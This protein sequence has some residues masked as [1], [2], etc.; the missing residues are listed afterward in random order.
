M[1]GKIALRTLH[2]DDERMRAI[3]LR[4]VKEMAERESHYRVAIRGLML[5]LLSLLLR[6]GTQERIGIGEG[7]QIARYYRAIEPALRKIRDCYAERF[8]VEE[9]SELCMV[10]KYHFCRVFKRV[11]GMSAMQYLN[12]YRLKIAETTLENTDRSVADVARACGFEDESYFCRCYKKHFGVT[13][14]KRNRK[15]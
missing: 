14:G 4:I 3:L 13:P 6:Y 10:S 11:T 9:M 1:T 15:V 2:R 12:E 7:E 5:E 8:T